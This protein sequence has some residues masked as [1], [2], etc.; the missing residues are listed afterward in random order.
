MQVSAARIALIA[1]ALLL[2]GSLVLLG[3][4]MQHPAP[5]DKYWLALPENS[6]AI[7]DAHT[8]RVLRWAEYL[9]DERGVRRDHYRASLQE[10]CGETAQP[11][12]HYMALIENDPGSGRWDR[13]R[14]DFVPRSDGR[15]DVGILD[16]SP[17]GPEMKRGLIARKEIM[18]RDDLASVQ[19]AW[20][21]TAIWGA[22]RDALGCTDTGDAF[23][24]ACL[25]GRYYVSSRQ[26]GGAERWRLWDALRHDLALH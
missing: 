8:R 18:T 24:E 3:R 15:I 2:A 23:F 17:A 26:C 22:R 9:P 6:W 4:F 11:R 10:V 13:Y 14:F 1:G 20:S 21:G 7:A 5:T 16:F 12:E 25:D 19:S